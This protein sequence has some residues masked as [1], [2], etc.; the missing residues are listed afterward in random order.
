MGEIKDGKVLAIPIATTIDPI[1]PISPIDAIKKGVKLSKE[2]M[3]TL[4][5]AIESSSIM[6]EIDAEIRRIN[7][8]ND[9]LTENERR[10]VTDAKVQLA[11]AEN[12]FTILRIG[13]RYLLPGSQT[14]KTKQML[15]L[16]YCHE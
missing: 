8:V 10:M 6:K 7:L 12:E 3:K 15:I 4:K 1:A 5:D 14:K 13:K 11:V 16:L 9:Y 2:V